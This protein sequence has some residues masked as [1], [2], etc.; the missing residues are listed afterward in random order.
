MSYKTLSKNEENWIKLFDKYN[1]LAEIEKYKFFKITSKQINKYRE[2]RLMTKFDHK[3]NLP[4]LFRENRLSI[5]PI[6]RGSYL[7]GK[8]DAYKNIEFNKN[9]KNKQVNLPNKIKSIELRNIYSEAIA[10]NCAYLCGIINDLINEETTLTISGRMSTS[11]FDF[12]VKNSYSNEQIEVF[13]KNSQCEIDG[14]FESKNKLILIE[15]KNYRPKDFLIRQLYYPFRLWKPKLQ[16]EI[17]PVF[18][19]YS[20]DVFSFYIYDF[21]NYLEYNSLRLIEQKNYIIKSEGITLSDIK[22]IVN[23][24]TIIKEP[25]IP[26]PQA[27]SFERVIDLLGLLMEEDLTAEAITNNYDFTKR[28]TDYYTNAC[29]YLGL[30]DK[31]KYNN[32]VLYYLSAIGKAIMLKPYREK[33]LLLAKSILTHKVFNESLKLRIKKQALLSKEDICKIMKSL[34]IY[35]VEKEST[36]YRRAQTVSKWIEWILNLQNKFNR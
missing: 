4:E 35:K 24:T 12:Y 21:E 19:T 36:Y 7:I 1:I 28:Q 15:A 27:D 25:G 34:P 20:N 6:S 10:L 13:V 3:S 31:K 2:S 29:K 14:G 9:I 8:F 18:M 22:E 30:I 16:K 23:T 33:Y 32:T 17:I 11:D 5:F 26:F